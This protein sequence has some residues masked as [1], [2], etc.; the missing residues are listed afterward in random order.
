MLPIMMPGLSAAQREPVAK[1]KQKIRA[2]VMTSSATKTARNLVDRLSR[3]RSA[4]SAAWSA[5]PVLDDEI[6][7]LLRPIASERW[8]AGNKTPGNLHQQVNATA[9][10]QCEQLRD[11]GPRVAE[12]LRRHK[13][14]RWWFITGIIFWAAVILFVS[15]II[16]RGL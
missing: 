4:I 11:I 2:A 7:R 8:I 9:H 13:A 10:E 15:D 5:I 6:R 16:A 14:R 1:T 12:A 3:P